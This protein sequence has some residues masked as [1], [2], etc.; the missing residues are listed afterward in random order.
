[1]N[2]VINTPRDNRNMLN[3]IQSGSDILF[4]L[5]TD[6]YKKLISANNREV[7][8]KFMDK[9]INIPQLVKKKRKKRGEAS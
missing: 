6:K 4:C 1:M 3:A 9:G 5:V 8:N 7:R 2:D